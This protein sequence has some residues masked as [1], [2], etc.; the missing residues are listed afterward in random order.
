M[1]PVIESTE[2]KNE[3]IEKYLSNSILAYGIE[4]INNDEPIKLFCSLKNHK[5]NI[6]GGVMGYKTLNLFFITH[7]HVEKE[8]RNHGYAKNLLKEIE[9]KAKLLGCNILRLN[10]LNKQTSSLYKNA[11]FEVTN[12]IPNYMTGFD[13]MYYHK[14][15]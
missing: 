12:T 13:L 8:H 10:T 3:E 2:F 14:N 7:L 4:Q 9:D 11:G 5:G 1:K 6:I 15:I